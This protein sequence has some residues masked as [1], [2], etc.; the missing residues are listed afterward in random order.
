MRNPSLKV[1]SGAPGTNYLLLR[2]WGVGLLTLIY[3]IYEI[4]TFDLV[5]VFPSSSLPYEIKTNNLLA[6]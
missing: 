6:H 4:I 3:A 5:S 1:T 2:N